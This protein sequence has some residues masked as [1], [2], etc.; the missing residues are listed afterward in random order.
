MGGYGAF[1]LEIVPTHKE[2]TETLVYEVPVYPDA[3][4]GT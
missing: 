4:S 2:L 3:T 1:Q